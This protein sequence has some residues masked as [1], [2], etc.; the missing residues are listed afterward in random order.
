MQKPPKALHGFPKFGVPYFLIMGESYY[1]G[2]PYFRKLHGRQLNLTLEQD[3]DLTF[4]TLKTLKNLKA[5]TLKFP[6]TL[7]STKDT[8]KAL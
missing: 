8:F 5:S 1:V 7:Q 4:S 6:K 3:K 2:V